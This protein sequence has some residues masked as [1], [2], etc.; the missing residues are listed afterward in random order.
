MYGEDTYGERPYADFDLDNALSTPDALDTLLSSP[1]EP[2]SWWLRARPRDAD[3]ST[4]PV[5]TLPVD[6]STDG[7]VTLSTDDTDL[8]LPKAINVPYSLVFGLPSELWGQAQTS[9]GEIVIDDARGERRHL[10]SEDWVGRDAD[11]YVGPHGG[12]FVQFAKVAE[13]ITRQISC[14]RDILTLIADDFGYVL[15]RKLQ[16]TTYA[17]TGGLEG[18]AEIAGRPK[19]FL[20]GIARQFTPVLVDGTNLIYQINDGAMESVLAVRDEGVSES[21]NTDVADITA[22][23]PPAGTY[24]TSLSAGFIRLGSTPAGKITVDAEG[25]NGSAYGYVD[26]VEGLVKL[27]AV[28]FA[29]LDDPA[30]LDPTAFVSLS[31]RTAVMGRFITEPLSVREVIESF[32]RSDAAYGWLRPNKVLTVGRITDPDLSTA[33]FSADQSDI[34]LEP[35]QMDPFEIPTWKVTVGYRRYATQMSDSELD[36]SVSVA[37]RR[38]YA[39]E[40]RFVDATDSATLQQVPDA[41]EVTILTSLDDSSDAQ[42]LA[43]EQ[44]AMRK[45]QRWKATFSL[46]TG[47]ISRGIG[48]VLEL[49]DDRQPDS[50]KKWAIFGVEN[51]A[52]A[53]GVDDKIVI[54]C[55]G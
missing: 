14:S 30:N 20:L 11:V 44:L 38:D 33:G 7:H 1:W 25:H 22:S 10:A 39:Q 31:S 53:A 42:A 48:D 24:N 15:D 18:G 29:G 36:S 17:G 6:L 2:R 45:V 51:V 16:P 13:L 54:T 32:L 50:P 34:K 21:F 47:L 46:R 12:A 35:W 4:D 55:Y 19:P 8:Q 28:V 5:T 43:D 41:S 37:T 26:T 52:A 23:V 27:L 3:T 49:T 40:Y 9:F